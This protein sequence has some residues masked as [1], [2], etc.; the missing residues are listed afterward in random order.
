MASHALWGGT[1]QTA[2]D[3]VALLMFG[4]VDDGAVVILDFIADL[5]FGVFVF[6][7]DDGV[8]VA[9]VFFLNSGVVSPLLLFLLALPSL[10]ADD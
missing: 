10:N 9:N 1:M 7:D 6:V 2:V 5:S 4:G 3:M 8:E